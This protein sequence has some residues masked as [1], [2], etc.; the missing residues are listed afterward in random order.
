LRGGGRSVLAPGA[1]DCPAAPSQ[2]LGV[3]RCHKP[4]ATVVAA[5]EAVR[6]VLA[7]GYDWF[8]AG[9]DTA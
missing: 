7:K 9:F 8:T 3:T 6:Q 4:G 1:G 5:G 2:V